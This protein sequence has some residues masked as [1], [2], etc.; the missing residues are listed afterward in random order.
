M[1]A[2]AWYG[3]YLFANGTLEKHRWFLRAMFC[4]FPLGFIAT[5]SGWFTAEVGRQPWAIYGQLRTAD[6]GTPFLTTTEVA[7]TLT[8]FAILYSLIFCFGVIYVYRLLR[9][10]PITLPPYSKSSTN[11]KRPLSIAGLSPGVPRATQIMEA[12]E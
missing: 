3:V 5:L 10:G 12:G 1:L 9:R 7:I 2:L 6:A 11:P 4:S 8:I